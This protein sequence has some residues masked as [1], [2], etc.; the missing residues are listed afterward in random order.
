MIGAIVSAA[1]DNSFYLEADNRISGIRV[2]RSAHGVSANNARA[3]VAGILRTNSDGE[4]YIE[5]SSAVNFET[6]SVDPLGMTNKLLGGGDWNYQAGTVWPQTLSG[7]IG[8]LNGFGLNNIGMLVRIC[9]KVAEIEPVTD[10][11]VATWFK[12]D[13]GSGVNV[14]CLVPTGV[15]IDPAWSYVGVTG[16]SSCETL[17]SLLRVRTRTDIVAY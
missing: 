16:V 9:G 6:G 5:A 1:W 17:H 7:Q 13:D 15:T 11:A 2:E 10:P 4:R 12:I 14:K 3:N 8:V